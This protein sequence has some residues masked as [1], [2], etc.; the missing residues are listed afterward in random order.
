MESENFTGKVK[1]EYSANNGTDWITVIDSTENDGAYLWTAPSS[2]SSNS[3]LLISDAK[4]GNPSDTS[5]VFIVYTPPETLVG[6][7]LSQNTTWK[8]NI[9]LTGDVIVPTNVTLTISLRTYVHMNGYALKS[10]GGVI[11][12]DSTTIFVPDI[13]V[14]DWWGGVKG[15]Y[16][17]IQS[18]INNAVEKEVVR[19][20]AGTFNEDV[21]LKNRSPSLWQKQIFYHP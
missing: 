11:T 21:V 3:V 6:G 4:D 12:K 15:H 20:G 5:D 16:S 10:T 14:T 1:I 13:A 18:A 19:L 2:P 9:R 7:T 8:D 17:S